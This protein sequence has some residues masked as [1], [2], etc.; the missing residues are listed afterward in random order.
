[1]FVA[2]V[3]YSKAAE[4]D[5]QPAFPGHVGSHSFSMEFS[6]SMP[7]AMEFRKMIIPAGMSHASDT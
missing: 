6:V 4:V 7:I 1:M 2:L 5:H 3:V